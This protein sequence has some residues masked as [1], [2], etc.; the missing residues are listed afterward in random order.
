MQVHTQDAWARFYQGYCR[1]V[2]RPASSEAAAAFSRSRQI[3][4][5]YTPAERK[6]I[7]ERV[8]TLLR[9][10]DATEQKN[11]PVR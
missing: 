2:G 1:A 10:Q 11:Q 8:E 4:N 5:G 9:D 6:Q 7:L 3:L